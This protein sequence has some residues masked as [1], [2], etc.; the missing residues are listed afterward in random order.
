M[1][2]LGFI[3]FRGFFRRE[4]PQAELR[5]NI[6]SVAEEPV[7]PTRFSLIHAA[8]VFHRVR[9][10]FD[11]VMTKSVAELTKGQ[12]QRAPI[13]APPVDGVLQALSRVADEKGRV[14]VMGHSSPPPDGDA[15]GSAISLVRCLRHLGV[16]AV[17]CFDT[18][19]MKGG[20]RAVVEEGEVVTPENLDLPADMVVLTD[21]ASTSQ[22][23]RAACVLDGAPEVLVIDHHDHVP[24]EESL[25]LEDDQQLI[26][27]IEPSI[28]SASQMVI[29]LCRELLE[30]APDAERSK[31]FLPSL[32]GLLTDAGFGERQPVSLMTLLVA[33][34]LVETHF[35]GDAEAVRAACSYEVPKTVERLLSGEEA[36]DGARVEIQREQVGGEQV[37]W[38]A[39]PE[40]ILEEAFRLT[41]EA[42]PLAIPED[43][44]GPLLA[45]NDLAVFREKGPKS[46]TIAAVYFPIEEG[47]QVSIRSS[48]SDTAAAIAQALGGGGKA[49][50][51]AA[52]VEGD[53]EQ[54][55]AAFHEAVRDWSKTKL[56]LRSSAS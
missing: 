34:H 30:D 41:E 4:E 56:R 31:I 26:R 22:L 9:A 45:P 3:S 52:R 47:F 36:F 13:H 40:Q 53:A 5:G 21:V 33:K 6:S 37:Q 12:I 55:K 25:G 39:V 2:P 29:S 7:R 15:V 42:D 43:I 44:L 49:H 50:L 28:D 8:P 24:T 20:L 16:D 48:D 46:P 17:A 14:V 11:E 51:G 38:M 27:W 19:Q 54:V 18:E 23:G 35:D 10:T 1:R 32:V